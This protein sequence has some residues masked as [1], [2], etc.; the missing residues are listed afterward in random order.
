MS[1]KE[2]NQQNAGS[3]KSLEEELVLFGNWLCG[4]GY[5]FDTSE[6]FNIIV[7][8]YLIWKK[9]M[10]KTKYMETQRDID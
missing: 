6:E 2:T 4:S 1:N 10:E 7:E 9:A 8:H 5:S 3:R